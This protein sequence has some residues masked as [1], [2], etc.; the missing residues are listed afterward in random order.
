M[1]SSLRPSRIVLG[2]LG[3]AAILAL[4]LGASSGDGTTSGP[5]TGAMSRADAYALAAG[6]AALGK[7]MF[8]DVSLSASGAM[9][10]AS[11]HDP[12]HGFSP[13]NALPVQVGGPTL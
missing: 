10:C 9:S 2:S 6:A 13:A 7:Q 3:L 11:C 1:L 5:A 4:G 12:A 8:F